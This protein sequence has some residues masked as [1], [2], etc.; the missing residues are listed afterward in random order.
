M[1]NFV[2]NFSMSFLAYIL[3]SFL[4]FVSFSIMEFA[5]RVPDAVTHAPRNV[6]IWVEVILWAHI[7][8]SI[9]I[10]FY[11]GSKLNCLSNYFSS[12]LSVSGS[13]VFG[14]LMMFVGSY[15]L[16]L[17]QFSSL[18]LVMLISR[19]TSN[20]YIAIA[21]TSLLPSLATW[22]GMLYKPRRD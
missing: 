22:F 17:P 1:V 4:G 6:P 9:I 19:T 20:L 7:L 8:I 14:M 2:K 18:G 5:T 16:I 15:A 13:L 10:C 21:I 11:F 3:I 12:F